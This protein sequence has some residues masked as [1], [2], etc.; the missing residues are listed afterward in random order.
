MKIKGIDYFVAVYEMDQQGY[1]EYLAHFVDFHALNT[2]IRDNADNP[3][4]AKASL[5]YS[6]VENIDGEP[7]P[8]SWVQAFQFEEFSAEQMEQEIEIFIEDLEI[9]GDLDKK[10]DEFSKEIHYMG[11][12]TDYMAKRH[13]L[14][15][16][17]YVCPSCIRPVEDCHCSLYPYYLVQIDKAMVP[18]I[19][20]LNAKGYKTTGC[21]AGHPDQEDF[22][23]SGIYI[24]FAEDYDFDEPFPE[25][26][27]Y[28]KARHT[29]M[30]M[31]NVEGYD[32]LV[33]F[34]EQT[35]DKL[36]DWVDMLFALD[37]LDCS[38]DDEDK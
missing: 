3:K 15:D 11:E 29:I 1:P 35:L 31:P 28:S 22:L 19:R 17:A 13:H 7:A 18:I 32:N 25:G 8:F 37:E 10:V 16:I 14:A 34:Q 36:S 20:K 24:A 27:Q 5:C 21:C 4:Y 12:D 23:A 6:F 26:A 30:F 33:K 2:F 38:Y 9:Q